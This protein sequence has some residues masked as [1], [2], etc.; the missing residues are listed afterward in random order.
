MR[1]CVLNSLYGLP[2]MLVPFQTI[3]VLTLKVSGV[4]M[5]EKKMAENSEFAEYRRRTNALFSWSPRKG[6][7][8]SSI[9]RQFRSVIEQALLNAFSS[10]LRLGF[11]RKR[12][13]ILGAGEPM[14]ILLVE[15][16]SKVSSFVARGLME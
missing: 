3:T 15:D 16:E 12:H 8:I 6:C 10:P 9:G 14:R 11:I 2:G 5:L 1:C 13:Y 7:H 4:P